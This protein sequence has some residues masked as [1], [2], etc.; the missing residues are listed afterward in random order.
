MMTPTVVTLKRSLEGKSQWKVFEKRSLEAEDKNAVFL[1][2]I[3]K[4]L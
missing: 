1:L 4:M 2:C 3:L